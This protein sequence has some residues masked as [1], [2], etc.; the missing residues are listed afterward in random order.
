M[1]ICVRETS[2]PSFFVSLFAGDLASGPPSGHTHLSSPIHTLAPQTQN[3]N[4]LWWC[5]S[6]K[7]P[8]YQESKGCIMVSKLRGSTPSWNICIFV[9]FGAWNLQTI[10]KHS[11]LFSDLRELW[12]AVPPWSYPSIITHSNPGE[13]NKSYMEPSSLF[14]NRFPFKIDANALWSPPP[15]PAHTPYSLLIQNWWKSS[16][17]LPTSSSTHSLCNFYAKLM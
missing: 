17:A 11:F 13:A 9:H 6:F 12:Q 14:F 10:V 2:K 8:T 4:V 7:D 15:P 16:L 1:F 3:T 5:G